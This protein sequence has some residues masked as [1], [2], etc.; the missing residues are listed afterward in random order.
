MTSSARFALRRLRRHPAYTVLSILTL[1]IGVG[2][3]L[4]AYTVTDAA[5]RNAVPFDVD[6]RLI[7]I[8]EG[9]A[10]IDDGTSLPLVRRW[11]ESSRALTDLTA[12]TTRQLRVTSGD[13]STQIPVAYVSWQFFQ[14]LGVLPRLGRAFSADDDRRNATPVVVVSDQIWRSILGGR[15]DALGQTLLIEAKP[16]IVVG[17]MPPGFAFPGDVTLAWLPMLQG[18]GAFETTEGVRIVEAVGRL[19]SG[20]TV[21]AALADL[22]RI[23][24]TEVPRASENGEYRVLARS[25]RE[26]VLRHQ[27]PRLRVLMAAGLAM[28][29]LGCINV[30][31]MLVAQVLHRFDEFTVRRAVGA[32]WPHIVRLLLAETLILLVAGVAAGHALASAMV[33]IASHVATR[34]ELP[35]FIGVPITARGVGLSVLLVIVATAGLG[36]LA[37]A[38]ISGARLGEALKTATPGHAGTRTGTRWRRALTGVEVALTLVLV[39]GAGVL[40]KSYRAL[41]GRNL[42]FDAAGVFIAHVSRPHVVFTPEERPAVES[43][44]VRLIADLQGEPGFEATAITTQAPASGN[45]IVSRVAGS[46]PGDGIRVGVQAVSDGFFTWLGLRVRDGRTFAPS[47]QHD[48]PVAVIDEEIARKVFQGRPLGHRLILEDLALEAQVVGVVSHVRQGGPHT[49][50]LPQVYLPY[51]VLPLPWVTVVIRSSMTPGAVAT[52]LRRVVHAI[53]RQQTIGS[54]GRLAEMLADR[55]DRSRFYAFLLSACAGASVLLTGI[56]LYGAVTL[57]VAQRTREFGVRMSFGASPA[58]ICLLVVKE[59]C[60]PVIGGLL[61]GG[62]LALWTTDI[63]TVLLYGISPL[64]PVML[65][66]AALLVV[67]VSLLA[68][69]GPALRAARISPAAALRVE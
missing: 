27:L 6:N 11:R 20:V 46:G 62:V 10:E 44:M 16:H 1:G 9:T 57:L 23:A 28:L 60:V 32:G 21:D 8:G 29:V 43:F 40:A 14:T 68:S 66:V 51:N 35:E 45:G 69:I 18:F 25:L 33:R 48:S 39:L 36:L 37:Y 19:R 52:S 17:V 64:D 24:G 63:L 50:G 58:R 42:G 56:G 53:D 13:E 7:W 31:N 65:G 2:V 67:S 22:R 34:R 49:E 30:G 15:A 61:L 3:C 54:F 41:A 38:H 26:H 59:G 4:M 47:D 12:L 5:M 55:L